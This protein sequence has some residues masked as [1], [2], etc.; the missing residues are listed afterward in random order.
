MGNGRAAAI[1]YAEAGA[2]VIVGDRDPDAADQTVKAILDAGGEALAATV[3]V[4][5]ESS[6]VELI[7]TA[8][9]QWGRIDVL[10]NNVGVSL[11]RRRQR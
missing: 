1:T 3:D 4:T 8:R 10:H 6:I 11:A 2:K 5:D 7:E 9:G